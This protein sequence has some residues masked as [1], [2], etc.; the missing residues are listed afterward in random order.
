MSQILLFLIIACGLHL[1]GQCEVHDRTLVAE[2]RQFNH[3]AVAALGVAGDPNRLW[4]GVQLGLR[5]LFC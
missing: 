3:E 2:A 5:G 1:A 4:S